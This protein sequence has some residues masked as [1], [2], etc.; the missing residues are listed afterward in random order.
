MYEI[1]DWSKRIDEVCLGLEPGESEF[2]CD[3]KIGRSLDK[4]YDGRHKDFFFQLALRA[5]KVFKLSCSS[6]HQDTTTITFSGKY[7]SWRAAEMANR[8]HNKDHR[9]D[10]KQLVLGMTITSDGAVPLY[11]KV[12]SGNQSDDTL[13]IQNF[14]KIQSLLQKTDFIY[15]ADSKLA[16]NSNLSSIHSCGGKFITIMPR[17]WI[18]DKEFRDSVKAGE[19]SWKHLFK[20]KETEGENSFELAKG[21][22]R[23]KGFRVIWIKSESKR[24]IDAETRLH[25]LL[26]VQDDL[27]AFFLSLSIY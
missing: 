6:C 17:T 7:D 22:Y 9:P 23:A 1:Q 4:F 12:Y 20:K 5:I 10:L 27:N 25:R 8:G 16:T 26:K 21:E 2:I 15:V 18:E 14:Q 19:I 24:N 3:D 13:H 11:H